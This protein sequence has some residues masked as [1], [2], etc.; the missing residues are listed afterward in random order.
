MRIYQENE[1][2]IEKWQWGDPAMRNLTD[3]ILRL[4]GEGPGRALDVGCGSGRVSAA[5]S[6]AGFDVTGVDSEEKVVKLA[7]KISAEA[8]IR[9]D[10]R[11]L[12]F[13]ASDAGLPP[14]FF[15]LAVCSEV[16][17]HVPDPV[18]IVERI[19]RLLKPG[20]RLIL[21]VPRDPR[22]YTFLDELGG[23]L[24]RFTK[25]EIEEVLGP[26]RVRRYFTVGWP[27][28]RSI[29]WLYTRLKK[30][31]EHR[32]AEIW[33]GSP[34]SRLLTNGVYC[35]AKFDNLFNRFGLGTNMVITAVKRET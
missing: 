13:T 23:H 10:F 4:A 28:M 24:K 9:I 6:R 20:G 27:C 14:G 12:D 31:G 32:P 21:T 3:R 5:L 34:L 2:L 18:A 19:H 30:K 7:R 15:D 25:E 17:E 8:G 35:L 29:V 22:Q 1:D 26:F 33:S 11:V 16:L